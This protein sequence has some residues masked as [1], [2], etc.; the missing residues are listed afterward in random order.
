MALSQTWASGDFSIPVPDLWSLAPES[1]GERP[2]S[3]SFSQPPPRDREVTNPF[4]TVTPAELRAI[5]S[6]PMS[7]YERVLIL[8]ARFDYEFKGGHITS[9]INVKTQDDMQI[10]FERYRASGKNVLVVFHCEFSRSRGPTLLHAFREYDRRVNFAS[11][12][13]VCYPNICLLE[14]GYKQFYTENPDLCVGGYVPMRHPSHVKNG[15]LRRSHS[16]YSKDL[17]RASGRPSVPRSGSIA[18][19][20][21]DAGFKF[22]K[23]ASQ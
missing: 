2:L 1:I 20:L 13:D 18:L 21:G 10:I 19:G 6:D 5:M 9:A 3:C 14:G 12:P 17:F 11:Y 8:D 23:S 7:E 22:T 4:R 16:A 15:D